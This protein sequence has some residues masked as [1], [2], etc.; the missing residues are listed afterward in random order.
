MRIA[1][2]I[3]YS[4]PIILHSQAPNA[5][6]RMALNSASQGQDKWFKPRAARLSSIETVIPVAIPEA[7]PKK[8]PRPMPYPIPKRI[9]YVT[10]LVS[11]RS[12]P[13]DRPTD[14]RQDKGSQARQDMY[15]RC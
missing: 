9:E 15:L 14:H 10:A 7:R 11:S 6:P 4:S 5:N 8:R 2:A 12:G 13:S 1:N 3:P